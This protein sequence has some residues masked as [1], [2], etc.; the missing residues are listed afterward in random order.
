LISLK[1]EFFRDRA[2]DRDRARLRIKLREIKGN[3]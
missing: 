2:R 1:G 3:S